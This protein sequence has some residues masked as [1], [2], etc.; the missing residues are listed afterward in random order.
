MNKTGFFTLLAVV[1]GFLLSF[2]GFGLLWIGLNPYIQECFSLAFFLLSFSLAR[3]VKD[4]DFAPYAPLIGIAPLGSLILQFR[5]KN[6]S[7]LVP[8][9]LVAGWVIGIIAGA[10]LGFYFA[11]K[12]P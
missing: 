2:L 7:H 12:K 4:A 5:D 6:D 11:K 3:F 8:I 9:L 10:R 1:A